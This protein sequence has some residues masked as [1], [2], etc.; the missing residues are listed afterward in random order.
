MGP[1]SE[2]SVCEV[3][4]TAGMSNEP[5]PNPSATAAAAV[6]PE[7]GGARFGGW[8][9]LRIFEHLRTVL[10]AEQ[11]LRSERRGERFSSLDSLGRDIYTLEWVA[12]ERIAMLNAVNDIRAERGVSLLRLDD[13]A[14]VEQMASGHSDYTKKFALYCAELALDLPSRP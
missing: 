6:I 8:D 12:K 11:D 7:A 1:R 2:T 9:R 14:R 5:K 3:A 10:V 4:D 13:I